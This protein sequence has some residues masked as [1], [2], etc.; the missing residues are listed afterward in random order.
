L[1]A[2]DA[3]DW[4]FYCE[5][6]I[7]Y[8]CSS[9]PG[10]LESARVIFVSNARRS[11][12]VWHQRAAASPGVPVVWDYHVILVAPEAGAWQVYDPDS[13]LGVPT[14]ALAYLEA[15][16]PALPPGQAHLRPRFRVLPAQVYREE[17]RSDRRHMRGPDG[18]WLKPPPPRACI[19]HGSNLARFI[20]TETAFLGEVLDLEALRARLRESPP[21]SEPPAT[22]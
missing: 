20:D 18:R 14:N 12:A 8:R 9:A 13:S 16:F 6:N 19:G 7:W 4:P 21:D 1:T 2:P 17:L 10:L 3:H 15:C 11:V 22:T 5:E